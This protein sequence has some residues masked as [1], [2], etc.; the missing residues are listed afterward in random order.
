MTTLAATETSNPTTVT[1]FKAGAFK[2]V[3][4]N[5]YYINEYV[6]VYWELERAFADPGP[7]TFQLQWSHSGTP[8]GDDW[9]NA[10]AP[11]NLFYSDDTK[12]PLR[13]R[14]FGKTPTVH[15]RVL[16]T[17]PRDMYVSPIANV[18]GMW[19]KYDWLLAR[20]ILRQEQLNHRIFSSVRGY[21]LK[22]RR[23]GEKCKNCRD[24]LNGEIINSTCT[25]CYG[26]GYVGG[27]YPPTE[28]YGL[29]DTTSSTREQRNMGQ[30]GG[31]PGM[32]KNVT[33]T[34]R[35]L[36]TLPMI[37]ADA[38][39]D[40][41]SDERY[42]IH[43]VREGASWKNVPLVY[44]VELRLAPFTDILYKFPALEKFPLVTQ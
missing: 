21:L 8:R 30:D 4:V 24:T 37:Q 40:I 12:G 31:A 26:V 6:R 43:S 29:L 25:L 1:V 22:A 9:Q 34:G 28:Y 23:Y 10:A 13:Q 7:Y 42:Y 20:E 5:H 16:L 2:R 15:Y 38:W 44:N 32:S 33:Y 17:T 35:F 19:G 11:T 27:Y 14:M 3:W 36:A 41:T 39:I 18:L